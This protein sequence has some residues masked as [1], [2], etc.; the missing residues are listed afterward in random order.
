MTS[1][2]R[3][4]RPPLQLDRACNWCRNC[5]WLP[6]RWVGERLGHCH[7]GAIAQLCRQTRGPVL[8]DGGVGVRKTSRGLLDGP[9]RDMSR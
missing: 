5:I 4:R 9:D 8:C 3:W 6:C 1:S 2:G 7:D